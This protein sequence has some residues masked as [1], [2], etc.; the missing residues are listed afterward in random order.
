MVLLP[1]SNCCSK[2]IVFKSEGWAGWIADEDMGFRFGNGAIINGEGFSGSEDTKPFT[3]TFYANTP[4][5][6]LD[7]LFSATVIRATFTF[8]YVGYGGSVIVLESSDVEGFDAGS[9]VTLSTVVSNTTSSEVDLY[10]KKM[11][12]T[13]G[14]IIVRRG[15]VAA[16]DC[17]CQANYFKPASAD[18][19]PETYTLQFTNV[20]ARPDGPRAPALGDPTYGSGAKAFGKYAPFVPPNSVECIENFYGFLQPAKTLSGCDSYLTRIQSPI[21]LRKVLDSIYRSYAS[22]PI[23]IRPCTEVRYIFYA[24]NSSPLLQVALGQSGS[25]IGSIFSDKP[26]CMWNR[27]QYEGDPDAYEQAINSNVYTFG[28]FATVSPGGTYQPE[29]RTICTP[30]GGGDA[31]YQYSLA[32]GCN[33]GKCPPSEVIVKIEANDAIPAGSYSVPIVSL[34]CGAG[35][36]ASACG[37][38]AGAR[39]I[40]Q[41]SFTKDGITSTFTVFRQGAAGSFPNSGWYAN[42][43]CGCESRVLSLFIIFQSAYSGGSSN[44]AKFPTGNRCF[45]ICSDG[46]IEAVFENYTLQVGS[47][48]VNLGRVTVKF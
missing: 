3:L 19:V 23:L 46:S 26:P 27:Q 25:V 33:G 20:A 28:N 45:P 7:I 2:C 31:S 41:G 38:F 32:E 47:A 29:T 11:V 21:I 8:G 39:T 40:Y 42:D 30:P 10:G 36:N 18:V 15:G 43:D 4:A 9:E 34:S 14:R 37:Y 17:N 12:D 48:G 35:S 6:T 22:D 44:A 24:C 13:V 5:H 16:C 1:C